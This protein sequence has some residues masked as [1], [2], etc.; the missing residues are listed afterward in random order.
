SLRARRSSDLV[1]GGCLA[2]ARFLRVAVGVQPVRGVGGLEPDGGCVRRSTGQAPVR[3]HRCRR[4]RGRPAG[5]RAQRGAGGSSGCAWAA[6]PGDLLLLVALAC[7][8]Y[9]MGWRERGG[10][11]R[12]GAPP[13]ESSRRP[14]PGNPFSGLALLLRSRYLAGIALFVVLLSATT[15][16]LYFEQARLVDALFTERASQVRVFALLDLLVQAG[17]LAS[18]LFIT[19]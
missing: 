16:F 1:A 17:S 9:L 12:P 5:A 19:G 6:G 13:S 18:Q 8:H 10:A 2:G 14:I 11:G 4:Q 7:K 15:T 3:L